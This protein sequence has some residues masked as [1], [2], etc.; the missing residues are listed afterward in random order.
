M[1]SAQLRLTFW[2]T[3]FAILVVGGAVI[4]V[5]TPLTAPVSHGP[6][7]SERPAGGEAGAGAVGAA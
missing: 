7:G 5:F 3:V 6:A 1:G 2:R 4:I